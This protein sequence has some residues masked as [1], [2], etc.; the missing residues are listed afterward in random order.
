MLNFYSLC[1]LC[2]CPGQALLVDLKDYYRELYALMF[3]SLMRRYPG[4]DDERKLQLLVASVFNFLCHKKDVCYELLIL[5]LPPPLPSPL[6][7]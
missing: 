3:P 6:T 2:L 1:S 4:E 5:L 7:F